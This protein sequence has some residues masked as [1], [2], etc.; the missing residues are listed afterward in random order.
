MRTF[1]VSVKFEHIGPKCWAG[2]DVF[3]LLVSISVLILL[4]LRNLEVF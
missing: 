2:G 1:P 4:Y 3:I